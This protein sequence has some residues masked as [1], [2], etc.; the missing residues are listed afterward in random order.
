M[1]SKALSVFAVLV[2]ACTPAG[3][4]TIAPISGESKIQ[5]GFEQRVRNEDW[6]NIF[7]FSG[8]SNDEREQIR[9]RTMFWAT[10]PLGPN[11]DF[12]A[13]INQES[14]QK[15]GQPNVFD[16]IVF[17]RLYLD[18]K[19]LFVKG[20]SLR[21]GRQ[22]LGEGEGFIL[23]EGTP[24]DG[25]RSIY[26]NALNLSYT[27]K[28]SKLELLGIL[29]PSRERFLPS[30]NN[31]HK[32]LQDWDDQA[33]GVYYTD[34]NLARTSFEGY[35][36]YK[37]EVHDR[38]AA[39]GSV[40]Q[41]DRHVSTLGG[42]VVEQIAPRVTGGD[43]AGER[44]FVLARQQTPSRTPEHVLGVG[45]DEAVDDGAVPQGVHRGDRLHLERPR[46]L[47]VLVDVDLGQHDLARRSRRRPARGSGRAAGTDRTTPPTDRR[48]PGPAWTGRALRSG[49]WRR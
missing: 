15:L 34:K 8:K 28:K 49:R 33:L 30:I 20:L 11:L 23:F 14:N 43:Q 48:R 26:F 46:D 21:V 5:F 12:V 17:D 18:F 29:D 45:A 47:R 7:D 44:L 32:P 1:I 39:L 35:Y 19:K 9:Y 41:P 36:F 42:R 13:G 37:K 40:I 6:N 38:L 3:A 4:Q 25:S 24:G 10:V 27:R 16:E 2:F 31:Q 22:N